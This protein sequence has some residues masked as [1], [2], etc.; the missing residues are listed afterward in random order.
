MRKEKEM[1]QEFQMLSCG[2]GKYASRC[3]AFSLS[4]INTGIISNFM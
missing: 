2:Q 4:K 1:L 3:I